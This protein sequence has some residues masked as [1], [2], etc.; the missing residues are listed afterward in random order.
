[1][2][3]AKT[4]RPFSFEAISVARQT[5]FPTNTKKAIAPVYLVGAGPGDP[6]LLTMKAHRLLGE[7]DVVVYDR[8]VASTILDLVPKG[9]SRIYVGKAARSHHM[10]QDEINALLAKLAHAGRTVVRLKGGDPY[11]FGRGS[12]E[13]MFLKQQGVPVRVVPGITAASGCAAALGVPL[14]ERGMATGVRFVTG[15][16]Q[17]DGQLDLNWGSLADPDTTLV[18]YMGLST[19][20]KIT[21]NL[22]AAGLGKDTPAAAIANGTTAKQRVCV[23]SL[24]ALPD[25]LSRS[26]FKAPVLIVIGKVAAYAEKSA[27]NWQSIELAALHHG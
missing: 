16:R 27:D 25:R 1:M 7:A 10:V 8:L 14:T 5:D 6:E 24:A 4:A 26:G 15:H 20:G 11:I 23:A 18:L 21:E 13:A 19:I 2:G 22:I 3:R 9:T 17:A 12:E